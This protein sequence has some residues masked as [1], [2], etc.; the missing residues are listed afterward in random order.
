MANEQRPTEPITEEQRGGGEAV[1][2]AEGGTGPVAGAMQTTRS[3]G[4][5]LWGGL[6]KRPGIGFVAAGG[7]G[8]ALASALGVGEAALALATGYVAYQYLR[9]GLAPGESLGRLIS[10]P[11]NAQG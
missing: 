3:A 5:R 1:Q 11:G 8:L 9:N 2:A 4:T 7:A 10:D 6:R